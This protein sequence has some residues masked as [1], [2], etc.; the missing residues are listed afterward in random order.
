MVNTEGEDILGPTF[1]DN[2]HILDNYVCAGVKQIFNGIVTPNDSNANKNNIP[3]TYKIYDSNNT[4]LNTINTTTNSNG[5]HELQYTFPHKGNYNIIASVGDDTISLP[6]SV[7]SLVDQITLSSSSNS[8]IKGNN[9]TLIAEVRSSTGDIVVGA[10]VIFKITE[11]IDSF[12][13]EKSITDYYELD[14]DI[15]LPKINL[16]CKLKGQ[17]G[18]SIIPKNSSTESQI[19]QISS[20]SYQT[21]RIV[22]DGNS[23]KYYLDN[24]LQGTLSTGIKKLY[25]WGVGGTVKELTFTG[26]DTVTSPATT[27]SGETSVNYTYPGGTCTVKAIASYGIDSNESSNITI[28]EASALFDGITLSSDKDIISYNGGTNPEH[29]VLTAQLMNGSSTALVSGETVTFEVR[30]SSDDSL[31][32]TLT[33]VTDASGIATV[34]YTSKGA[35]DLYI[36]SK[37][38][39]VSKIFVHDYALAM[40]KGDETTTNS[41]ALSFDS[42]KVLTFT[43][44]GMGR[45]TKT[46]QIDG[47]WE[48]EYKFKVN[49]G[50]DGVR[51]GI[52]SVQKG[53]TWERRL[54][55][56]KQ[57]PMGMYV[58][59][60]TTSNMSETRITESYTNWNT[61]RITCIN[62]QITIYVNNVSKKT[63]T[64]DWANEELT[65]GFE[66][67]NSQSISVEYFRIKP[68]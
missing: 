22:D 3:V 17:L 54:V 34:S 46:A 16:E 25:I 32:E 31:V 30:K 37:C 15:H 9:V 38:G 67:W 51:M 57:D 66:R 5:G 1:P 49:S 52:Q 6:V 39:L 7:E 12:T 18:V 2:T 68:L 23:L 50:N 60:C 64:I 10:D 42:N 48:C 61:I 26:N 63:G 41:N 4:L 11:N 65:L 35:G 44:S 20:N 19:L 59:I 53:S 43:P 58:D 36:K 62:N 13:E 27:T 40:F 47:D 8:V 24:I 14:Y 29:A 56:T 21:L 45:F 28:T 33:D 55:G